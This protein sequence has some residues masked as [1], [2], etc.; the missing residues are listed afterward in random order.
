VGF[1][2]GFFFLAMQPS[3]RARRGYHQLERPASGSPKREE[4]IR[5]GWNM[6]AT[7]TVNDLI[8]LSLLQM[9]VSFWCLFEMTT[10]DIQ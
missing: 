9:L 3:Y 6:V 1:E 7:E 8:N 4:M 2:V 5:G 10:G